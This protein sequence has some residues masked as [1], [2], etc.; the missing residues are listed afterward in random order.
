MSDTNSLLA[1]LPFLIRLIDDPSPTVHDKVTRALRSIGPSV[2]LHLQQQ[3]IILTPRQQSALDRILAVDDAAFRTAWLNWVNNTRRT[4]FS[5]TRRL[6]QGLD[7]LARWQLGRE[8]PTRLRPLLDSL[9]EEFLSRDALPCA[10][11]LALFLFEDKGLGGA[12]ADDY[13]NSLNSN[14]VW[15]IE[16]GHGLPITLACI[17]ILVGERVDVPIYGCNFPGHFM[18]RAREENHDLVFD[19]FNG[20]RMLSSRELN[21][22]RKVAP[23]ELQ[24]S[25]SAV[26]IITRV[27]HNMVNAYRQVDDEPRM[28]FV[29]SLLNDLQFATTSQ[30]SH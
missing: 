12:P 8:H 22:L 4:Q 11:E 10:E 5:D 26:D 30:S 24:N 17:F 18:A 29:L 19:C 2:T 27:L 28:N 6:E 23:Q 21:A 13:Y 9:A 20:G 15:A 25:P 16:S 14:A 1:Q 3:N 7:L